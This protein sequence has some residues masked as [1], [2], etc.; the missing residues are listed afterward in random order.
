MKNY[1]Y[2]VIIILLSSVSHSQIGIGTTSPDESA[3]LHL[4]GN[5]KGLLLPRLTTEQRNSSSGI[6]SPIGGI[7]IY[8][9]TINSFLITLENDKWINAVTGDQEKTTTGITTSAGAIGIGTSSIDRNSILDVVSTTKGILLPLAASDFPAVQ[10]MLYYNTVT[11][12][13]RVFDG[14]CWR[15]VITN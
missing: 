11:D 14:S 13:L 8:D 5:N 3:I 6:L 15:T 10:G 4:K 9:T 1:Y 12:T 7:V 2:L